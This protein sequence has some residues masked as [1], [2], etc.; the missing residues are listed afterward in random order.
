MRRSLPLLGL[1]VAIA[2]GAFVPAAAAAGSFRPRIGGALGLMPPIGQHGYQDIATGQKTPVTYHGGNVMAGGI[3]VHTVF[4]APSGYAFS[5]SP[6]GGAPGYEALIQQ[7]FTDAADDSGAPGTCSASECNALTVLTQY[8]EGTSVGGVTPGDYSIGY[9]TAADSIDDTD[10]Y[11]PAA[12]QCASPNGIQ[13]CVT[14]GQV[15]SE[16][17]KLIQATPGT[18]RGLHNLWFVFLP[19]NVDECITPGS[20]GTNAFAGYHSLS[21]VGHGV[22]IYAVAVDPLIEV[23]VPQGADPNGNPDAE[24]TVDTAAH[25]TVE[26]MTDPEGVGW[27][28]PNGFEVGD[29]CEFGP[30]VGTP[31]GYSADGSPFNQVINGHDYLIQEMWSND[32]NG[33]VQATA[34]TSNPLPLPQVNL[35]Q[36]SSTVAGNIGSDTSGVNVTVSLIRADA[37]GNPVTVASGSA[38]TAADGSWSVSVAPHYVGDDR[39]EIDVDYSGTGAPSPSH[40]VILT[41]NGGNPFTESGWTGW[42]DMDNGY[43]LTNQGGP[44]L[45]FGPCFQTGVLTATMDGQPVP[46]SGTLTDYCNSDQLA[47]VGLPHSVGKGDALTLSSNDNRGFQDP[48]LPTGNPNGALVKLTV[49]VGEPDAV[50]LFSNPLPLLFPT[51]FPTCTADLEMQTVS[52]QGLVPGESYRIADS[53]TGSTL[54]ATADPTGTAGGHFSRGGIRGGDAIALS[55]GSR[56]L[57]T[58]H[59][60]H[61]RVD[62]NGEQSVLSGGRCQGGDYYGGPLSSAPINSSAGDPTVVAGGSALTGE[63]CP[64]SGDAGGLP[65][66]VIEQTDDESG[67]VTQTEV[68]DVENTSPMNGEIVYGAFTVLA[69]S[70]LPGPNGSIIPTNRTSRIAVSIRPARSGRA[71]F[72]AANV[73]SARGVTVRGLRPGSYEATWKLRDANGDTR[74]VTTRFVEQVGSRRGSAAP[75]AGC[76]AEKHDRLVCT[77]RYGV[78]PPNGARVQVELLRARQVVALGRGAVRRGIAQVTLRELRHVGAGRYTLV[79]VWSARGISSTGSVGVRI[80]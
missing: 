27:M 4:W 60:A 78:R 8:A 71:V 18:P 29:K 44:S 43:V 23:T 69:Q 54:S 21:N 52:C 5:G 63:I 26:A 25:E 31:L 16:V 17:D 57:S 1:A 2:L 77:L 76:R 35:T 32:D 6:G 39:D 20:C 11:P 62:I 48:N 42:T 65:S 34:S 72:T 74:T 79:A 10:P 45:T 58:L 19:P 59:V 75:R 15:Q 53:R 64:T 49:P 41:G 37:D 22:T 33:C 55:N 67:G 73:D 36:F 40:E 7:F 70:G 13:T 61:L 30:Q 28:D 14:D 80:R 24:A 51:G 12:D 56:T 47:T 9:S 50:S 46:S 3:T 66:S 38:R 68:P